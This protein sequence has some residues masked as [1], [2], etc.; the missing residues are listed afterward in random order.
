MVSSGI[1]I[2]A[3]TTLSWGDIDPIKKD[4]I[5]MAGKLR[6]YPGDNEEYSTF[7]SGEAYRA[8]ED[9]LRYRES[10]GE[11]IGRTTPVLRDLFHPD[12]GGKGK[13]HRPHRLA[14]S[15]VKRLI[16]DGLKST[17]LRTK[18][19]EG[20]RRHEWQG[21]H[22]FRK[23]FK[24]TAEK[25]MKSLHVEI[26]LGHNT[27]PNESYYRPKDA[28]LLEDYEKA[29]PDLTISETASFPPVE[30]MNE[31]R[32]RVG[33]LEKDVRKYRKALEDIQTLIQSRKKA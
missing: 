14:A 5:V 29:L 30:D 1:R 16:E 12:R 15:G 31:L 21:A 27:G 7:I 33:R 9:Y 24:T 19:P 25:S 26:L 3:W 32:A 23:F 17:G 20:K 18:L 10:Q 13:P 8:I 11:K 22:G 4:G 28:E 2:G 6:V